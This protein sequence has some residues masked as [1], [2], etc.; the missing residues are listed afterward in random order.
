M[1]LLES[2]DTIKSKVKSVKYNEKTIRKNNCYVY[3][4]KICIKFENGKK[5]VIY[6]MADCFSTSILVIFD[7]YPLKNLIGNKIVSLTEIK[8]IS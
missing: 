6:P 3:N 5:I 1:K 4:N 8:N 2:F 7:K